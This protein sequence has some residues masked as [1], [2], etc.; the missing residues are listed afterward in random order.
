MKLHLRWILSLQYVD[1]DVNVVGLQPPGHS[2]SIH[3]RLPQ[4][5]G[6]GYGTLGFTHM[7]AEGANWVGQAPFSKRK[8]IFQNIGDEIGR[9]HV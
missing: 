1:D 6:D 8:H 5:L 7:G 9:A 3:L 4:R 2:F